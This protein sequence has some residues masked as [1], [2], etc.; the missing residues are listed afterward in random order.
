MAQ[1]SA[2]C[3][4]TNYF[5]NRR[6]PQ[7]FP[8]RQSADSFYHHRPY[9]G[10]NSCTQMAHRVV[11]QCP[12]GPG[13]FS[14]FPQARFWITSGQWIQSAIAH[15]ADNLT[16]RRQAK[17]ACIMFALG[18]CLRRCSL[19]NDKRACSIKSLPFSAYVCCWCLRLLMNLSSAW[20]SLLSATNQAAMEKKSIAT[21]G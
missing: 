18:H 4:H 19:S 2:A 6:Y 9:C 17:Q 7:Y 5:R 13:T 3:S 11:P 16:W 10:M 12:V 8:D 14:Y 1:R 15:W 20:N 21:S